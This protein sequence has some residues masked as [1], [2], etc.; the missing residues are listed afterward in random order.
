RELAER[1]HQGALRE[2]HLERV[3]LA[4]AGA[5]DSSGPSAAEHVHRRPLSY[6]LGLRA[7]APPRFGSHAAE[8]DA[9]G[10]HHA[11]LHVEADGRRGEGERVRGAVTDLDVV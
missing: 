8:R 10:A 9:R 2:L 1:A 5:L 3:V 11:A 4:G 6:E 7:R